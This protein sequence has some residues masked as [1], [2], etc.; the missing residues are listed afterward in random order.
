MTEPDVPTIIAETREVLRRAQGKP[1][2]PCG[3]GKCLT[4]LRQQQ[5]A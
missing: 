4:C 5:A 2:P 3:D 1:V